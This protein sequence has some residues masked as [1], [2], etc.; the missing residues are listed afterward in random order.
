MNTHAILRYRPFV[1][2]AGLALL[3]GLI[4]WIDFDVINVVNGAPNPD[5]VAAASDSSDPLGIAA[6]LAVS[7]VSIW[8]DR[9]LTRRAG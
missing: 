9:R 5:D 2:L 7:I 3:C 8:L 6:A 1:W 4:Q